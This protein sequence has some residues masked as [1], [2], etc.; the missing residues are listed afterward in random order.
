MQESRFEGKEKHIE[1]ARSRNKMLARERIEMVL[2]QDSPFLELLLPLQECKK[3][4]RF[5][6]RRNQRSGIG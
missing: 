5:W 1:K 4:R 2:D 3:K 6:S